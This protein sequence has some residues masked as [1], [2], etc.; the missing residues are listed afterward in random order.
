MTRL[1]IPQCVDKIFGEVEV[2]ELGFRF[3]DVHLALPVV[4]IKLVVEVW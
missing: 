3:L 2:N 4:E 1:A